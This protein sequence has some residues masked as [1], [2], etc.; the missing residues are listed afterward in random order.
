MTKLSPDNPKS[1]RS[2]AAQ[3]MKPQPKPP[4]KARGGKKKP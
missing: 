1:R 4:K 3:T 2:S